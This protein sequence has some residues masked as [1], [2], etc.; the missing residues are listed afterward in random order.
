M[1]VKTKQRAFGAFRTMRRDTMRSIWAIVLFVLA[2]LLILSALGSAGIVGRHLYSAFQALFGLGYVF[3]P[4]LFIAVGLFLLRSLPSFMT[5]LRLCGA[6][7]FFLSGLS[8]A[9][10]I[11]PMEGGLIGK[12]AAAPFIALFDVTAT[13]IILAA[14]LVI[15]LI[16][17][18]DAPL[19]IPLTNLL[20]W[21]RRSVD[22]AYEEPLGEEITAVETPEEDIEPRIARPLSEEVGKRS[23]ALIPQLP[24]GTYTPPPLSLLEKDRGK[25]GVGDIKANANLIKRTL[26]NFGIQVEMDEISIGPSVT[27]YTLKPAEGVR[28][29]KIIG[30]QTN[31]ELALA[32]HPVR[33]EAPIPG[34]SLVGIE[35]PNTAK[36]TADR[37]SVV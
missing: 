18:I 32:A 24:R 19:T 17:M 5:P 36:A 22:T 7:L 4:F 10:L 9:G 16:I 28:L 15:A 21:R 13:L 3:L 29:S 37:K 33:I 26:Q 6:S 8:I 30:L 2:G 12:Y 27:R 20:F 23:G 14:A 31:F 25:P 34:K 11:Q 35:V 1:A